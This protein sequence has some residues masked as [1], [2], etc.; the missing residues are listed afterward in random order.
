MPAL[1]IGDGE[2]IP[3]HCTL[4]HLCKF[5][6]ADTHNSDDVFDDFTAKAWTSFKALS[7][8]STPAPA[9]A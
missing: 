5:F 2:T 9:Q 7:A 3:D 4:F 6:H 1:D 8:I